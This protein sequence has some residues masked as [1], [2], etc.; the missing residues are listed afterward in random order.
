VVVFDEY[1][2]FL[3]DWS[4]LVLQ[5]FLHDALPISRDRQRLLRAERCR[6]PGGA[7][8]RPGG[9]KGFRRRRGHALRR[10]LHPRPG[11]RPAAHGGGDRKS[12]RLNSS[13]VKNSYAAFCLKEKRTSIF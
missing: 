9:G 4:K 2:F 11:I 13:H 5:S 8:P 3:R 1:L 10:R 6:G 7:L 12:T